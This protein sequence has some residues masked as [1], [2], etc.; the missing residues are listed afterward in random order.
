LKKLFLLIFVVFIVFVLIDRQR[1]F[2]RDPLGSVTR[3][4]VKEDGAQVY[5]NYTNEV[6]LQ[7]ENPPAYMTLVQAA[8]HMG[9]PGALKCI[10]WMAC[11]TDADVATLIDPQANAQP[12]QMNGKLV[13]FRDAQGRDVKVTLR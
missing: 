5:I 8:G 9:T 4:G 12:A 10:H 11:L 1:I 13:E 3:D 6:L 2:L 7:N